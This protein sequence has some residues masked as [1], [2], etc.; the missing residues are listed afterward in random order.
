MPERR[1]ARVGRKSTAWVRSHR[2][3]PRQN[4]DC[5]M[6]LIYWG[7]Y[8]PDRTRNRILA[9]GLRLNSVE[10][11][12][13]NADIWV[14]VRDKSRAMG[15]RIAL[16]VM[17]RL[18]RN[19][20][21]L[22]RRYLNLP[23]HEWVLVG[24]LGQLDLIVIWPFAK[25]RRAKIVWNAYISLYDTMVDDRHMIANWSPIAW[26]LHVWEWLC[27]RMADLILLDTKAHASYF[28]RKY[29]VE[30]SRIRSVWIGVEPERFPRA[31][32][33]DMTRLGSAPIKVLHFGQMVPA[34]GIEVIL[35][36][37][38]LTRDDQI[39]WTIIGTGQEETKVR[40]ALRNGSL[41][42]V[43]WTQYVSQP[44]L[45]RLVH[46]ADLC[47]GIFG[48]SEKAGRVIPNKVF[49][50]I[51]AGKPVITRDSE[52]IREVLNAEMPGVYLVPPGD[53]EALVQAILEFRDRREVLAKK[54]LHQD[55][56]AHIVPSAIGADLLE[57]LREFHN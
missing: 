43:E 3:I 28:S 38:E 21:R 36:A 39:F 17:V 46:E 42:K 27:C 9:T 47:L 50:T 25:L 29:G 55:L 7:T 14:D 4:V 18:L 34:H 6:R 16:T 51:V 52:G 40:A 2:R 8:D 33:S 12:E 41:P 5:R 1:L 44:E 22:I 49:E 19:Y 45:I 57:V 10:V 37:A 53:P 23:E 13:C 31:E 32:R 54:E 48:T 56:E 24:Y 35:C 30:A 11:I 26:I 15:A 20:P